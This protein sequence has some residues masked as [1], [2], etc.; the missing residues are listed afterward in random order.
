MCIVCFSYKLL[1]NPACD[2]FSESCR[3]SSFQVNSEP[4]FQNSIMNKEACR[5]RGNACISCGSSS[6]RRE[7]L[8]EAVWV[9]VGAVSAFLGCETA[10]EGV[11]VLVQAIEVLGQAMRVL[12]L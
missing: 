11:W 12:V 8:V 2:S 5:G 3:S 9:L 10:W 1:L 7:M 4:L 6:L